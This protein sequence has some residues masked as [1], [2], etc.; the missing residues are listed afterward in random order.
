MPQT[1]VYYGTDETGSF[2][3]NSELTE[4]TFVEGVTSIANSR[5]TVRDGD[6]REGGASPEGFIGNRRH[7]F[8]KSHFCELKIV[9]EAPCLV[10]A[11]VYCCLGHFWEGESPGVERI[12]SPVFSETVESPNYYFKL[13]D[14]LR[15]PTLLTE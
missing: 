5:H 3:D 4:V 6:G 9:F 11:C 7:S 15:R 2:R 12:F 8:Y 14:S 10:C 13:T 1:A